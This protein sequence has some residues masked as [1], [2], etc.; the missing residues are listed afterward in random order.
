M[1]LFEKVYKIVQNVPKGKV[2]S[3]GQIA[4]Q[5]GN[6]NLSRQVGY[7]L[8]V[9]PQ[10]D[11]IPCYRVVNRFGRLSPAFAFGGEN[12]QR[13]LLTKE[14]VKFDENGNVLPEFFVGYKKE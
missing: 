8:H 3:Y 9:N 11:K 7:A 2:I 5:L 6:K 4:L 12:M 13:Q 14:G 10:P 1:N